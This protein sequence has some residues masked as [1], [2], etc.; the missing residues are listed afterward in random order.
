[1]DSTPVQLVCAAFSLT[2][3]SGASMTEMTRGA[4]GRIWRL[5]LGTDR[6][7]VKE[8]FLESDEESVRREG[9]FAAHLRAAGIRLPASVPGS[10]GRFLVPLAGD[11]GASW[12]RL[13]Q[14]I[15]GGPA[16]PAD[17]GLATRLG[18]ILGRLHAHALP[19]QG[20][21]D[22][23]YETVPGRATWDQLAD[24]ARAQGASWRPALAGRAAL[25]AALADLL[26][27]AARHQPGP[28]HSP[29]HPDHL[30]DDRT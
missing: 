7:A 5:D 21:P 1:M 28:R 2:A 3:T 10:D 26:T 23:W 18:D 13:Y 30:L 29:L 15:D 20:A 6:S 8:L 16:D 19:A 25:P 24:A 11:A 17:P 14:W 4:A 9:A 27:P 12:L 22:P